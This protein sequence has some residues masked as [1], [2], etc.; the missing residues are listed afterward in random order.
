M[1]EQDDVYDDDNDE[2]GSDGR[3]I[4][5]ANDGQPALPTLFRKLGLGKVTLGDS[6]TMEYKPKTKTLNVTVKRPGGVTQRVSRHV[7]GGFN[8]ASEYDANAMDKSERNRIIRRLA[9][10]GQTQQELAQQFGLSQAMINRIVNDN[11]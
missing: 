3:Q 7:E 8:V 4:A 9:A 2:D 6:F 10:R 1:N 5:P 11:D